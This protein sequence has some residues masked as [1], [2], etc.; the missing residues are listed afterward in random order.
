MPASVFGVLARLGLQALGTYDGKSIFI[1]AYPQAVGCLIMGIALPLKDTFSNYAPF[2]TAITT[3]FCGSLTTFSGWQ[4]DIFFSWINEGQYHRSG[5]RDVVDGVGKVSFTLSISMASLFLGVHIGTTLLPV[6]P[7]MRP[8]SSAMLYTASVISV[9]VY[10]ATFP[11]YFCLSPS[12][13][14]QATA[15]LLFSFPGTLMRY[16]L[17]TLLNPRLK[18]LPI[19]TLAANELGTSLLA[20]FHALQGLRHPVSPSA[21]SILQG[22]DD[23][24][25]GCLTTVSTFASE[26]RALGSR[27][28]LLYGTISIVV[29]QILMVLIL[30]SA[31]WTGRVSSQI[32]C[33]PIL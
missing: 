20:M 19:G 10:V 29:G 28:G 30:G 18:L 8:P 17:S 1:L 22:L 32:S 12:F 5:L 6:I 24:Y 7:K 9:L 3:G 23:G 15:A 4:L 26:L 14:H 2:Y 25:C 27:R 16:V 31:V 13:R 33:T 21:C 11:A